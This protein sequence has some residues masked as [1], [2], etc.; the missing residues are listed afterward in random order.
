VLVARETGSAAV[1]FFGNDLQRAVCA[2]VGRRHLTELDLGL[3]GAPLHRP[4]RWTLDA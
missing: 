1:C 3:R 2:N 4:D